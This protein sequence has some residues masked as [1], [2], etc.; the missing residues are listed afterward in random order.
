MPLEVF[1]QINFVTDFIQL[2]LNLNFIFKKQKNRG[3]VRTHSIYSS[4]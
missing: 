1:V 4:F 2:K 3:L